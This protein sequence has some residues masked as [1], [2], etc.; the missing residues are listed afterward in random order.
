MGSTLVARRAGRK[1]AS[2]ETAIISAIAAPMP[3][4]STGG[5]PNRKLLIQRVAPMARGNPKN[6][7]QDDQRHRL[8]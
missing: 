3:A 7:P 1:P 5:V 6:Q 2:V 8:A 4:K